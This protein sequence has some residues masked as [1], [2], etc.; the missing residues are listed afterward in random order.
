MSYD[1]LS[2]STMEQLFFQENGSDPQSFCHEDL[3][4]IDTS[5]MKNIDPLLRQSQIE[6]PDFDYQDLPQQ[7]LQRFITEPGRA[8]FTTGPTM[9]HFDSFS[10]TLPRT[11]EPI[12]VYP[13]ASRTRMISPSPSHE[14]SS[15]C[16]SVRSPGAETDWYM[17]GYYSSQSQDDYTLPNTHSTT[18]QGFSD[19]WTQPQNRLLLST[20]YPCVN[21]SDVQGFAD[22]QEIDFEADE[23]YTDMGMRSDYAIQASESR[24]HKLASHVAH[25]RDEA[26]G[27][28]IRDADSSPQAISVQTSNNDSTSTTSDADADVDAEGDVEGDAGVDTTAELHVETEIDPELLHPDGDNEEEAPSDAE[29]TPRPSARNP[30]KRN[31]PTTKQHLSPATTKRHRISKSTSKAPSKPLPGTLTCRQCSAPGFKDSATLQRHIAS[32][33]TRAYICVFDFAGCNSTFA[34]KN[35]WKRHVSS[36]HLNL[37]AW[38]C[39]LGSCGKVPLSSH[40]G[41][42]KGAPKRCGGKAAVERGYEIRGAEFNRKDLFTQHL[43]RMHAPFEV[44]RKGKRNGEWEERVKGLQRSCERVR[45]EAPERLGCPVRG[46]GAGNG[47]M[48]F[49]GRGCWDERMEHLGKHLER[50]GERMAVDELGLLGISHQAMLSNVPNSSDVG[51]NQEDDPLFLEWAVRVG[52]IER[53]NGGEW[54]LCAG[55]GG[56]GWTRKRAGGVGM[57]VRIKVEVEMEEDLDAEGEDE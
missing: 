55:M 1:N 16:S 8:L 29:Y 23:A 24:S 10:R 14:L 34:S 33:H 31:S 52:I 54:K 11:F 39:T 36:Q 17:D 43:R 57:G 42:I 51:I 18:S 13:Q 38:V 44:K 48:W 3:M 2:Y 32:S 27:A 6:S 7:P 9:T 20:G 49:E 15:N 19:V 41:A 37:Q 26:L 50:M 40:S 30:R 4:D 21:L 46:C 53:G 47:G 5:W 22:P 25:Y 28:S 45:R 56:H 35:E 12:G